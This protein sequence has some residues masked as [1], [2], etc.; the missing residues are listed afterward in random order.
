[1]RRHGGSR[2]CVHERG[3]SGLRGVSS[4]KSGDEPFVPASRGAYPRVMDKDQHRDQDAWSPEEPIE[5]PI[6]DVLDLH[7]FA[8]RDILDV[9]DAYLEAAAETG[10]REVRLI[11]GKGTGFQRE[12]VQELLARHALVESFRDAP[13]SRGPWGATVV[14]LRHS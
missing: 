10:F 3:G 9:V 14:V 5:I 1:M 7:P 2:G 6:E 11:H 4:V 13:P 8:P 12:R